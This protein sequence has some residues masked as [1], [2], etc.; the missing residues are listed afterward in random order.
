MASLSYQKVADQVADRVVT[1]VERVEGVVVSSTGTIA[2]LAR[3]VPTPPRPA[4]FGK[5]RVAGRIP[6]V[7]HIAETNFVVLEKLIAA[8]KHYAVTVLS[9]VTGASRPA[10]PKPTASTAAKATSQPAAR[11][12]KAAPSRRPAAK[13]PSA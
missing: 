9:A 6:S 11:S 7:Q 10:A 3:R 12:A 1:G 2:G 4:V 13:K 5:T 8:Q